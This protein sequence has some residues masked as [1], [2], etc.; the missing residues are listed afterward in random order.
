MTVNLFEPGDLIYCPN[1]EPDSLHIVINYPTKA[2]QYN[3]YLG[4]SLCYINPEIF[5]IYC[6]NTG[7]FKNFYD[8]RKW[9]KF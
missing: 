5:D 1:H 6:I 7:E 9:K 3:P 2:I 8:A 4:H